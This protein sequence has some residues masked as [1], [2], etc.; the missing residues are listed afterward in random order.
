M[1]E[2]L[3]SQPIKVSEYFLG[4]E[5]N[6]TVQLQDFITADGSQAA[7]FTETPKSD[8]CGA[9]VTFVGRVRASEKSTGEGNGEPIKRGI[10]EDAVKAKANSESDVDLGAEAIRPIK[11]LRYLELE[12][13]P[14]M[15]ESALLKISR[16]AVE[17]WSPLSI[18]VVH[19]VGRL[20]VGEPIVLVTVFSQHR[21]SAFRAC[22]YVM[23]FLKMDAPFWKKAIYTDGGSQWIEQHARDH[24]ALKEWQ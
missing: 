18:R 3:K 5:I 16:D 2:Q 13:Y 22:E 7:A 6:I 17:R 24:D 14:A 12:H 23:D 11:T 1:S 20:G 8:E 10:D 4:C 21:K 9:E 15:T 19:R